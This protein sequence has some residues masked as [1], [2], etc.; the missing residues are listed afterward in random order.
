MIFKM[1]TSIGAVE[2]D[3]IETV[4]SKDRA[5]TNKSL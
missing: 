3:S 4:P 1:S 5:V 2:T